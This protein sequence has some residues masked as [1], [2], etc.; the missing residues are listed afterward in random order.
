MEENRSRA[1]VFQTLMNVPHRDYSLLVPSLREAMDNDPDFVAR[2]CVHIAHESKIRDQQDCAIIALLQASPAFPEYREAG[3]CLLLG[4]DVYDIEPE[5]EPGLPP[6]RIFRVEQ[7]IRGDTGYKVPRL[8]R[9]IMGD[10][11]HFLEDDPRR[12]DGVAVQNRK[13][14]RSAYHNYHIK[15][16]ERAEW[17]VSDAP[18]PADSKMEV[19]RTIANSTDLREQIRLIVEEKIPYR[20]AVSLIGNV[21]PAVGMALLE[22]MSPTEALNSRAWIERSGLL[23]VSEVRD[24]YLGKIAKVKSVASADHRKSAQGKDEEVEAV[25]TQAKDKAVATSQIERSTLLL[26]DKSG[27]MESSI[28]AG[29]EFGARIAPMCPDLMCVAFNDYAQEIKVSGDGSLSDWKHAFRGIRASGRTSIGGAL[30]YA[31]RKGF[32]PEQVVIISDGGENTMPYYSNV[33]NRTGTQMP[34]TTLIRIGGP[35]GDSLS[36]NMAHDG[37]PMH[38]FEFTGDYYLFDQVIA[39]LG[40]PRAKSVVE[41]ILETELPRRV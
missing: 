16:G 23:D 14:L 38:L 29:I 17:L 12:F 7:H 26:V 25:L 28:A 8:M 39:L 6:F 27:S 41:A 13:S 18:L 33:V 10:Y 30:E 2:A 40:G 5:N 22:V 35:S 19:V 21:S 9:G 37:W 20:I 31:V 34:D 11:L 3:R 4:S 1:L 24:V 32:T 15:A 36:H